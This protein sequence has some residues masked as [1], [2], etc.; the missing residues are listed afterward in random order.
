MADAESLLK[1]TSTPLAGAAAASVT[2]PIAIAPP[3]S[4]PGETEKA[5]MLAETGPPGER[6]A[7]AVSVFA[8]VAVIVSVDGFGTTPMLM[9]NVTEA[10]PAGTVRVAG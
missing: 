8:E 1:L 3:F 5:R 9:G 4:V 6:P 2:V 10:W 7:L